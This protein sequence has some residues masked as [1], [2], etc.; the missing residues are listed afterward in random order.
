[1]NKKINKSLKRK[2]NKSR[3]TLGKSVKLVKTMKLEKTIK[4]FK[5]N[6]K[7]QNQRTRKAN[8]HIQYDNYKN[9][10]IG[11]GPTNVECISITC[12]INKIN[13]FNEL[14]DKE[15][16]FLNNLARDSSE[17]HKPITEDTN[18]INPTSKLLELL[19]TCNKILRSIGPYT[20]VTI[21]TKIPLSTFIYTF[22]ITPN[23]YKYP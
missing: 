17:K 1:M 12:F 10:K 3:K 11:G 15:K 13:N 16:F 20:N 21:D 7:L 22:A 19:I 4:G 8:K 2:T 5:K 23:K 9:K 18:T 14:T 6:G